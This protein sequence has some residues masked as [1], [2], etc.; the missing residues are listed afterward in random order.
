[1]RLKGAR[2]SMIR[3]WMICRSSRSRLKEL[4]IHNVCGGGI[5][6]NELDMWSQRRPSPTLDE[7]L[8]DERQRRTGLEGGGAAGERKGWT[9]LAGCLGTVVLL[10]DGAIVDVGPP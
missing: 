6:H 10:V 1:M 8:P 5:R 7:R 9:P 2:P 4:I 3:A